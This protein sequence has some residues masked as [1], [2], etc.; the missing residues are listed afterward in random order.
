MENVNLDPEWAEKRLLDRFERYVRI[1]TTSD[2][3]VD[4]VPSTESQWELLRALEKELR[5]LGVDDVDLDENG[6][7]IA[8]LAAR[9]GSPG[10]RT[11]QDTSAPPP[12]VGFLAHVDT[13][14]EASGRNVQP[15]V[16]R[17]YDG[18]PIELAEGITIDPAE[19]PELQDRIGDTIITSDGTTLLGADDKA[20]VAEIL[21]AVE[22]LKK[23]PGIEHGEIEIIFTPD[24]ET[25]R[26]MDRFPAEKLKSK[27]CYTFDGDVEGTIEAECFYG[28]MA[29]VRCKGVSIHPGKGRGKLMNAVTM[30]SQFIS[31]LPRNESPEATDGRY[32]F[33]CPLE[34]K[35][36]MGEAEIHLLVRDFEYPEIERRSEALRKIAAAVEAAFP[37]SSVEVEVR[38]QYDNLRD[39]LDREPRGLEF[40]REAVRMAGMEP[41]EE[42]IRGGT[43]GAR[44]S[45]MGIPTPNVFTGGANYHS[46]REWASLQVMRKAVTV[47]L[48]IIRLWA[49]A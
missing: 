13:A 34:I 44:L 18:K 11:E 20:G 40:L 4:A 26:G 1:D 15:Q 12:A 24:E 22:W 17:N 41:V 30:A 19:Y 21:T 7:L 35:G 46:V 16:H 49:K 48:N 36:G 33:Y 28:C 37:G 31:M 6:Y 27:Y 32:G 29:V 43:D 3:H 42:E 47:L 45:E 23:S 9:A 14:S 10:S 5:E 8:R 39:H 2:R 38:K 25:G